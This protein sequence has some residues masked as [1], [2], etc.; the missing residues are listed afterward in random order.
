M[1]VTPNQGDV[2][3][4]LHPAN[5]P[6]QQLT[7]IEQLSAG[8]VTPQ[9]MGFWADWKAAVGLGGQGLTPEGR[10]IQQEMAAGRMVGRY[11]GGLAGVGRAFQIAGAYAAGGFIGGSV[12]DAGLS[13]LYDATGLG[14]IRE[15]MQNKS[16]AESIGQV[17]ARG[18][19]ATIT[20]HGFSRTD[21]REVANFMEDA[22]G[23]FGQDIEEIKSEIVDFTNR[24]LLG[25]TSTVEEFKR[26][27]GRL[28]SNVKDI[29]ETLGATQ[30]E[31]VEM[32]QEF[33]R[34]GIGG[35][36]AVSGLRSAQLMSRRTGIAASAFTQQGMIS[37]KAFQGT[38]VGAGVGYNLGI[39]NMGLIAAGQQTGSISQNTL[40]QL[41]GAENAAFRL[42]QLQASFLNSQMGNLGLRAAM[43]PGGGFNPAALGAGVGQQL[44]MAT[45]NMSGA[46]Y[47]E[48]LGREG[49]LRNQFLNQG[50]GMPSLQ[51]LQSVLQAAQA[52]SAPIYG[53]SGGVDINRLRGFAVG[54]GMFRAED[55]DLLLG[56]AREA[57]RNFLDPAARERN[58]R[59]GIGG[60]RDYLRGRGV[61]ERIG[62]GL[63]GVGDAMSSP[64]SELSDS[65]TYGI[66]DMTEKHMQNRQLR[67]YGTVNL[68]ISDADMRTYTNMIGTKG[69]S[70]TPTNTTAGFYKDR[71]GRAPDAGELIH[72]MIQRG[73]ISKEAVG[74]VNVQDVWMR[75][76]IQRKLIQRGHIRS[77]MSA[78]EQQ[79]FYDPRFM[80][81]TLASLD[82]NLMA[83]ENRA[84]IGGGVMVLENAGELAGE[85]MGANDVARLAGNAR[86]LDAEEI[87]QTTNIAGVSI[88]R[89][90][91]GLNTIN[92]RRF[93]QMEPSAQMNTLLQHM[94]ITR[95]QLLESENPQRTM[96]AIFTKAQLA[97]L[98][99]DVE[100]MQEI[101]LDLTN[102]GRVLEGM[103]DYETKLESTIESAVNPKEVSVLSS[104][105]GGVGAPSGV[106]QIGKSAQR[107]LTQDE[108]QEQIFSWMEAKKSLNEMKASGRASGSEIRDAENQLAIAKDVLLRGA[109]DDG[110]RSDLSR[111]FE[112][113]RADTFYERAADFYLP[114]NPNEMSAY[115]IGIRGRVQGA[116][117]EQ[118][119]GFLGASESRE[120]R[121]MAEMGGTDLARM[122]YKGGGASFSD[123]VQS[124]N[125]T[126]SMAQK[127]LKAGLN[128][129]EK[130]RLSGAIMSAS[131]DEKLRAFLV[132]NQQS[133]DELQNDL[134]G[135]LEREARSRLVATEY[136]S[137]ER[138]RGM[139][140]EEVREGVASL[141]SMQTGITESQRVQG[142]VSAVSP[143]SSIM[144]TQQDLALTLS[145]LS[146]VLTKLDEYL[147]NQ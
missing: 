104:A 87:A 38:G 95:A 29:V 84:A 60:A 101:S 32:M 125:S 23:R 7:P 97:G 22:A 10:I 63:S 139:S 130:G 15:R 136:F 59:L 112:G 24:G 5:T 65:I 44:D 57:Q 51:M 81:E 8:N 40:W 74:A 41:G 124:L 140:A 108:S 49:E 122:V 110:V 72:R 26:E 43:G 35:D 4:P 100:G 144:Q 16:F 31:A 2:Y 6:R 75:P 30:E 111:L 13:K 11:A 134:Q 69:N 138:V 135:N 36:A 107:Y 54:T 56:S 21:A 119:F 145:D 39:Q 20:G 37:A 103:R 47:L 133:Y 50:R 146:G 25:G 98:N 99:V 102:A 34:H 14:A 78:E 113:E 71:P 129:K 80:G 117:F 86:M 141:L 73:D 142:G 62:I 76:D 120:A 77:G 147:R 27:F 68:K 83:V 42:N 126:R 89:A 9:N 118:A 58:R 96:N 121:K 88:A 18:T 131:S 53:E 1:P 109:P 127:M 61:F 116:V 123:L 28:K 64:F 114:K 91:R 92:Q 94:G 46:G 143:E 79:Y 70:V 48:F 19:G 137:E 66:D 12:L 55:F 45:G 128:D 132:L 17:L 106:E 105:M 115:E 82:E 90:S 52:S 85:I 3:H 67:K 33:N 93:A